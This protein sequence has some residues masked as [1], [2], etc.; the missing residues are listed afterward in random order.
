MV[1]LH[2][3]DDGPCYALDAV[4]LALEGCHCHLEGVLLEVGVVA[5]DELL[6]VE[7]ALHSEDFEELFAASDIVVFLDDV[8]HAVPDDV[9]DVHADAFADEG[10][11]ALLVDHGAL[12]VFHVVVFEQV[13]TDTEVVFLDFLLCALD[14][15]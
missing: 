8:D 13:L 7:R 4:G 3:L 10:V 14:A 6:F 9:G 5:F 1:F 11:A 15:L 2:L 12:L